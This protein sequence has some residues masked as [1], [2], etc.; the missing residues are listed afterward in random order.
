VFICIIDEVQKRF[1]GKSRMLGWFERI[2]CE[3]NKN[4]SYGCPKPCLRI[5]GGV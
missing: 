5:S 4:E 3:E 1:S 2:C